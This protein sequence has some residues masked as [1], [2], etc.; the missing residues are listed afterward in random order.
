MFYIS[1]A[2]KMGTLSG[3]GGAAGETEPLLGHWK[4]VGD[5][6]G[7]RVKDKNRSEPGIFKDFGYDI[8]ETKAVRGLLGNEAF[9]DAVMW[10][11]SKGGISKT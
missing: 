4:R 9:T 1:S 3:A 5:I 11:S 2:V 10:G 7:D 6:S 8:W